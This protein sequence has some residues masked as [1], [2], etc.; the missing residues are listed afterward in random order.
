[1]F[2]IKEAKRTTKKILKYFRFFKDDKWP[3]L[4]RKRKRFLI[5]NVK[6]KT[7]VDTLRDIQKT[8][9]NK[10]KGAYFRFGDEDIYLLLGY[11]GPLHKASK[12]M[13][14]E[15]KEAMKCNVGENHFALPI[16]SYLFGYEEGMKT[17]IHLVSDTDA[18]K[19]LAATYKLV[20]IHKIYT[21]VALHHIASYHQEICVEFLK[22]IKSTN[23]IFVGNQNVK[24]LLVKKLFGDIHIKTPP[25]N[26]YVEIDRVEKELVEVL[27]NK[28]NRFQVVVIAM[29]CPGRILQKR[30]LQNGYDVYLFDFGSLLDAFNEE[31]TRLWINLAGGTDKLRNILNQLDYDR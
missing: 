4:S 15:M 14:L 19:Y 13:S 5:E 9:K 23:P 20:N 22:F 30:I 21:P 17:D 27:E 2:E 18:V 1:M 31:N 25:V 3:N 11:N 6:I 8:I 26:S 24:P 29:G 12:K 16:N 28:K 7:A 10:Q